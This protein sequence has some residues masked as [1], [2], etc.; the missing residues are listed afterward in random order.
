MNI[1]LY[2]ITD[3]FRRL[4]KTMEDDLENVELSDD[5]KQLMIVDSLSDIQDDF[6]VKAINVA[7]YI[8]NLTF[9]VDNMKTYEQRIVTK[10]KTLEKRITS[11]KHYLFDNMQALNVKTIDGNYIKLSLRKTPAKVII[12]DESKIPSEYIETVVSNKVIKSSISS[13]IK[14]GIEV[15]GVRM[16]H[17][18]SL[19]IRWFMIGTII[20]IIKISLSVVLSVLQIAVGIALLIVKWG[21][22]SKTK[23]YLMDKLE[24]NDE[25]REQFYR[26]DGLEIEPYSDVNNISYEHNLYEDEE[27]F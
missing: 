25:F 6:N 15:L 24:F 8:Q 7:S 2:E 27:C 4:I 5:E 12:V 1:S 23:Q 18:Q 11:L 21:F 10:R 9:E 14:Q 19:S 26:K 13:A 16:E 20:S 3:K 22:M 17:G